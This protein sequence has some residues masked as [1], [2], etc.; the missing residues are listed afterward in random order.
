MPLAIISLMVRRSSSVMPGSANGG[1]R[2]M[3]VS[4]WPGGPTVIQRILPFPDVEADLEAEGVAVEGQGG[5][6]VVVR[7]EWL[8]WMVMAVLSFMSESFMWWIIPRWRGG[9]A[10]LLDS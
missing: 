3:L 1:V 6:G 4:G 8:E 10:R 9:G 5:L 2:T 7:Q